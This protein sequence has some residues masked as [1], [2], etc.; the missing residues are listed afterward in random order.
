MIA[1]PSGASQRAI[2]AIARRLGCSVDVPRRTGHKRVSHPAMPHPIV[3]N[4]RKKGAPRALTVW[5][6]RLSERVVL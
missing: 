5:L 6:R 1:I 4:C 3:F 2:L